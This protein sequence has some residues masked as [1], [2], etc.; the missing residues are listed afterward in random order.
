VVV[1]GEKLVNTAPTI[2]LCAVVFAVALI[3]GDTAATV[4]LTLLV[5]LATTALASCT[6]KTTFAA[7]YV[8][9]GVPVTAPVLALRLSPA[10]NVPE[11]ML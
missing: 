1:R 10:G 9:V 6:E 5:V 2:R 3:A 4:K 11:V 7:V 8:A